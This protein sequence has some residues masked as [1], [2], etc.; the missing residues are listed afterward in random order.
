M[1]YRTVT[2]RATS[3]ACFHFRV[4]DDFRDGSGVA[5]D[6]VLLEPDEIDG[7]NADG[8]P[9]VLERELL[10]MVPAV[11]E[12]RYVLRR[13][14]VGHMAIVAS[15]HCVMGGLDPGIVILTHDVAIHAGLGIVTEVRESLRVLKRIDS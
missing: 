2:S 11:V 14:S 1:P 3:L 6:A 8:F 4:A 7:A 13:K 12:L 5:M 10:A 15:R 9:E